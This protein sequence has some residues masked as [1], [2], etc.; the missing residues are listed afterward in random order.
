VLSRQAGTLDDQKI[1][2]A[3]VDVI[4]QGKVIDAKPYPYSPSTSGAKNQRALLDQAMAAVANAT[5]PRQWIPCDL[6]AVVERSIHSMSADG[7]LVEEEITAGRFRR[8][9]ALRVDWTRTPWPK[10]GTGPAPQAVE[11][12][13]PNSA[14]D[15]CGQLVNGVVND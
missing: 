6:Q 4:N 3:I 2:R 14:E 5:A 1:K 11:E 10:A 12:P 9:R 8:G 13:A 15:D 7:W